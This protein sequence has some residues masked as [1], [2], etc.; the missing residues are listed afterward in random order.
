[1][2]EQH[3]T[4]KHPGTSK[5]FN[6]I[7]AS[8]KP[9]LVDFFATWCGPC[10]MMGMLLDDFTISYKNIHKV[11]IAK[12]DIDELKEIALDYNVMSVPTLIL[13][14]DGKPVETMVG[15]RPIEEIESKLD[16]LI[17]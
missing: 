9:V 8:D 16:A 13:F 1:M 10:Q 15:M 12:V 14:N 7:I 5:T 11:E 4:I 2:S 6:E 17:K 3:E